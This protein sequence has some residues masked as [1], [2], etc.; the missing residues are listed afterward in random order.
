MLFAQFYS[1]W[2]DSGILVLQPRSSMWAGAHLHRPSNYFT[3][4]HT[5]WVVNQKWLGCKA[6]KRKC[7]QPSHAR[8]KLPKNWISQPKEAWVTAFNWC[9]RYDWL[10]CLLLLYHRRRLGCTHQLCH[11][12][13]LAWFHANRSTCRQQH[14]PGIWSSIQFLNQQEHHIPKPI[15]CPAW[16]NRLHVHCMHELNLQSLNRSI[17]GWQRHLLLLQSKNH[18][19]RMSFS[20]ELLHAQSLH[21]LLTT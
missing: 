3:R 14:R 8:R 18:F 12:L 20:L 17:H 6:I 13:V 15:S 10:E 21:L 11:H 16:V 4:W 9:F 1:P 7:V 2:I 5:I 19:H